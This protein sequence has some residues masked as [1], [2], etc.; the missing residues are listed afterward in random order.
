MEAESQP[1]R[2]IDL[3]NLCVVAYDRLRCWQGLCDG[4]SGILRVVDS[5]GTMRAQFCSKRSE[6]MRHK[7]LEISGLAAIPRPTE[8]P[9]EINGFCL[10]R[11]PSTVTAMHLVSTAYQA[12]D[13]GKWAMYI[14]WGALYL[15]SVR[16]DAH[17]L[18]EHVAIADLVIVD[19]WGSG[20]L[21]EFVVRVL[22]A[23]LNDRR[24]YGRPTAIRWIARPVPNYEV[25]QD[26]FLSWGLT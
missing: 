2:L 12:I 6:K 8:P 3:H 17:E 10:L 11:P 9:F 13:Q 18:S 22:G 20:F 19:G 26:L 25:E 1:A 21:P 4:C 7:L 15:D 14:P 5:T 16:L 23:A 24:V